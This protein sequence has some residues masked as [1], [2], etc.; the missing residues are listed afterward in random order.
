MSEG[1][2]V[3]DWERLEDLPTTR[4]LAERLV[5]EH[6]TLG[7]QAAVLHN[8]RLWTLA[9]GD[10]RLGVAMTDRSPVHWLCRSKI[11]GAVA[12]MQ[13]WSA[14][15][16]ALDAPVASYLD[17]M[18][19]P[20]LRELTLVHLLTHT[21]NVATE[22][23]PL[24]MGAAL[25]DDPK[26]F[27][28]LIRAMRTR[29]VKPGSECNYSFHWAWWVLSDVVNSA[30]GRLYSEF[31]TT[32]ILDRL[33]MK[34]TYLFLSESQ[35]EAMSDGLPAIHERFADR[36]M[37]LPMH[38][39]RDSA[40]QCV[41]GT[42]HRGPAVDLIRL[43]EEL[44][45]PTTMSKNAARLIRHRHR[46]GIPYRENSIILDAGLGVELESR[47]YVGWPVFSHHSSLDTFGHRGWGTATSFVDDDVD[48]IV[49]LTC[50]GRLVPPE[51]HQRLVALADRIYEDLG[52]A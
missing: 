15:K 36:W 51:N 10:A 25:V 41:P 26:L 48:L 16:V 27:R 49:V 34:D 8:G 43:L 5:A 29:D 4:A 23:D 13:L 33:R 40:T 14:G 3:A 31:V 46:A 30:S 19:V 47:Q 1:V 32:E 22:S 37:E 24:S 28:G 50:N 44:R 18:D 2:V 20:H 42:G 35:F 7:I 9:S 38:Q 11:L 12:V 21:T 52:L 39:T 17:W 6:S 45:S